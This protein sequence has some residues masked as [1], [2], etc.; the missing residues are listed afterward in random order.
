ME[1]PE[2]PTESF[3][4][5]GLLEKIAEGGMA[6][7]FRAEQRGLGSISRVVALKRMLPQLCRDGEFVSMFLDEIGLISQLN[8]PNLVHIYDFG[9]VSQRYYLAMEYLFGET[10]RSICQQSVDLHRPIPLGVA[11]QLAIGA[12][13]GLHYAHEFRD[14]NGPMHIVHRDVSPSNLI[15]TFDSAVKVLD[16]GVA[17]AVDRRQGNTAAGTIKGK[18]SYCAPEQLDDDAQVDRRADIFSLGAVIY[19]TLS[20]A[21]LFS[22]PTQQQTL[23]AVLSVKPTP[24]LSL[25]Q[26]I[27]AALDGV[28]A[29]A[30]SKAPE[31][32]YATAQAFREDLQRLGVAPVSLAHFMSD[33]FGSAVTARRLKTTSRSSVSFNSGSI[34][35]ATTPAQVCAVSPQVLGTPASSTYTADGT[36]ILRSPS[37]STPT[38]GGTKKPGIC[39]HITTCPL[40][41]QFLL[42]SI[43]SIWKLTYCEANYRVCKRYQMSSEGKAVPLGLLPNGTSLRVSPER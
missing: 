23:V 18:L 42:D 37:F 2:M 41:P 21:A 26:D 7:V 38:L 32:R 12:C 24:L 19:E 25:R 31:D 22:R 33:L 11:V 8:H 15:I 3:G 39:P 1:S 34:N 28:L 5:Y 36:Q 10:V 4:R 9:E 17:R 16:F 40:F 43:L 27:P 29:R 20:G 6:E 13:D 35:A 30:L 14:A